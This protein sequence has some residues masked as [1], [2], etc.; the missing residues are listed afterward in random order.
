MTFIGDPDASYFRARDLAFAGRYDSARDTLES[1]LSRYPDYSDVRNL[2]AKTYSWEA[3]YD[4][5]R[6]H[7]NRITSVDRLNKE[8]WIA[9]IDNEVRAGNRQIALGLSLKG[10][11]YLPEDPDLTDRKKRL[12][13]E[14]NELGKDGA[15]DSGKE[16]SAT[17]ENFS[18]KNEFAIY[19]AFDV[20]DVVYEPMIYSGVEYSRKTPLGKLIPRINYANRFDIHGLQY[21]MDM[22]PKLSDRFYG[23]LNYGFS[24]SEIF[25]TH[26]MGAEIYA[27]IPKSMEASVGIR[28]LDFLE[29]KTV[30]YTGSYGLYTGNYYFSLRP[31][32]I[33]DPEGSMGVSGALTARRYLSQKDNYIGLIVNAGFIPE[34]RQLIANNNLLAETLFFIE[35]QQLMLEYQFHSKNLS[36]LYKASLGVTHKELVFEPGRFF[37]AIT[38]GIKYHVR[39]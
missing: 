27:T 32:L 25:P 3:D 35:S 9:S 12:E 22:Y 36:N 31:Y 13:R 26:R 11:I 14:L 1:I 19:N 28:Y 6:R 10:L 15:E 21:E 30:I 29:E 38:A 16:R 2:L 4:E 37:W 8:A 23:Y 5:A 18:F 39:F 20:F 7:L 24:E 33:P 17:S 34:L